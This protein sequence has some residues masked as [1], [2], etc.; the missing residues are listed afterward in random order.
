MDQ[1]DLV[2]LTFPAQSVEHVL[3]LQLLRLVNEVLRV[4]VD[5]VLVQIVHLGDAEK[6]EEAGLDGAVLRV[7]RAYL[8]QAVQVALVHDAERVL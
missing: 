1:A 4:Q 3:R 6:L 5:C 7:T 8:E 2:A